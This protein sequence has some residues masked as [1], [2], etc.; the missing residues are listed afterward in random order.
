[1]KWQESKFWA[2]VQARM[3]RG[4]TEESACRAVAQRMPAAYQEY[5]RL[6]Y[7]TKRGGSDARRVTDRRAAHVG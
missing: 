3:Q 6:R 1:M 4:E 2:A 5:R 7:P